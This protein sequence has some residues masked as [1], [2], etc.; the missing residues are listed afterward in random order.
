MSGDLVGRASA[1]FRNQRLARSL[2]DDRFHSAGADIHIAVHTAAAPHPVRQNS[3]CSKVSGATQVWVPLLPLGSE[4][5]ARRPDWARDR[6]GCPMLKYSSRTR[7]SKTRQ[8]AT[9]SESRAPSALWLALQ[10][11]AW[12]KPAGYPPQRIVHV[13]GE[14][15]PAGIEN[16]QRPGG[17]VRVYSMARTVADCFKLRNR[18]GLGVAIEALRDGWQQ[19][20]FTLEE[21]EQMAR[22]CRVRV[23]MRPCV[24]TLLA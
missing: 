4:A 2:L 12:R 6:A 21:L 24:E 1:A 13:A 14:A 8:C 7:F 18:I 19:R 22:I 3:L 10:K 17:L 5:F 11:S 9:S 20:R 16:H 15:Y 23:V